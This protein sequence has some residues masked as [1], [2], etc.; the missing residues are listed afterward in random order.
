MEQAHGLSKNGLKLPTFRTLKKKGRL[1]LTA[2]PI[3]GQMP[4]A[5]STFITGKNPINHGI[6]SSA[7]RQIGTYE[8][9]I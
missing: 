2:P 5:W 7:F 1:G 3:P 9:G 8:E 6:F 4:V